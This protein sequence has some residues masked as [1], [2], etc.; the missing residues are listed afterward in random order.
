VSICRW[1]R[2][3]PS[4]EPLLCHAQGTVSRFL[5]SQTLSAY[6]VKGQSP[7][8]SAIAISHASEDWPIIPTPSCG[9]ELALENIR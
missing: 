4:L 9:T 7:A 3:S 8:Y 5:P 1:L 2:C 6:F